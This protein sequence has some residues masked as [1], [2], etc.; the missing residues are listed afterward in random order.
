MRVT[1][2]AGT[3][4]AQHKSRANTLRHVYPEGYRR[5]DASISAPLS[6]G[7]STA[8]E[9]GFVQRALLPHELHV[10]LSGGNPEA[11][12]CAPQWRPVALAE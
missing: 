5:L 7:L 9:G 8:A 2:T 1:E 3:A 4:L 11:T 10:V 6:E 12:R